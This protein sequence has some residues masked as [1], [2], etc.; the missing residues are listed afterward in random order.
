[1]NFDETA[2]PATIKSINR[3][4]LDQILAA[5]QRYVTGIPGGRRALLSFH[6]LSGQDLCGRNLVEAD[7]TGAVMQRALLTG[8]AH[9]MLAK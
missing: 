9:G 3:A 6:D 2:E 8:L 1:M 7:L 5:H 4:A